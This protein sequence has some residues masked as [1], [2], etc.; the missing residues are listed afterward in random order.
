[1]AFIDRFEKGVVYET[2]PTYHN[3]P[4][5]LRVPAVPDRAELATRLSQ[6]VGRHEALRT[7]LVFAA[8]DSVRQRVCA[9]RQVHAAWLPPTEPGQR[10][11]D[12]ALIDWLRAPFD[13]EHDSLF[14]VA[15]QPMSD[16]SAWLALLGHQAVVDRASLVVLAD[17]LLDGMVGE[18]S[19]YRDWLAGADP[20]V[21]ATDLAVQAAALGGDIEPIALPERET[22]A[23]VHVYQERSVPVVLPAGLDAAAAR[24][25]VPV[26]ALLLAAFHAVLAAYTGQYEL[27]IGTV[28]SRR[29]PG[30]ERVVGP[31]ANLVPVRLSGTPGQDF[32]SFATVA[33]G[34]WHGRRGTAARSSTI[35]FG[36]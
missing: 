16:G 5:V 7:N 33:A 35:W 24:L 14:R 18:P 17:E 23:A 2:S 10:E 19:S 36:C 6:A 8:D 13:L 21:I 3:L 29:G 32:R 26:D 1:M 22:R 9:E 27:V 34:T 11:P 4:L 28:Q 12:D 30:E 31:L 25:G 15:V 20:D